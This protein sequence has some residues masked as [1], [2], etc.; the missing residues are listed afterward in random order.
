MP[1]DNVTDITQAAAQGV[2]SLFTISPLTTVLVLVILGL[3]WVIREQMK[4]NERQSDKITDALIN[5]T[6]ALTALKEVI[7]AGKS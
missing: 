1:Q 4:R 6:S 2:N 5:N 3:C 7:N